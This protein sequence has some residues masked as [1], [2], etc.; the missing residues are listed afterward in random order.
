MNKKEKFTQELKDYKL[1]FL[2]EVCQIAQS[3]LEKLSFK[4][5]VENHHQLNE[6]HSHYPVA[7]FIDKS[8]YKNKLI[9]NYYNRISF[10]NI[11]SDC[12]IQSVLTSTIKSTP[13]DLIKASIIAKQLSVFL[14][15]NQHLDSKY[16]CVNEPFRISSY[17]KDIEKT[18][19]D[20]NFGELFDPDNISCLTSEN[21]FS[22]FL[23]DNMKPIHQIIAE[24]SQAL[25]NMSVRKPI[26]NR[27]QAKNSYIHTFCRL[28]YER[29]DYLFKY[30]KTYAP[31]V[32]IATFANALFPESSIELNADYV[33]R[34][35][36][37][38]YL[39]I[40]KLLKDDTLLSQDI[41]NIFKR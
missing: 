18:T 19:K 8:P 24:I 15:T 16:R 39:T 14:K 5:Y 26:F 32:E 30:Q 40:D 38:E 21:A 25:K 11:G 31:F 35:C 27:H 2:N 41:P 9:D 33:K 1:K 12:A 36:D 23:D 3:E 17:L 6:H 13:K 34:I 29:S 22:M 10:F 37:Y 20:L 7:Y 4:L 28:F